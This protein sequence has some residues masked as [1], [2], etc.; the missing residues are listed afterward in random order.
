M[1]VAMNNDMVRLQA[2]LPH[3]IAH[4]EEHA[5]SF[6]EWAE[7]ARRAGDLHLAEHIEAAAQKI[8]TANTDLSAALAHMGGDVTSIPA[9]HQHYHEHHNQD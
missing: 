5:Q 7:R 3:W 9:G 1:D 6:R 4:N 8:E 2:L